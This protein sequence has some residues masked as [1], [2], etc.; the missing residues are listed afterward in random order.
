MAT[1]AAAASSSSSSYASIASCVALNRQQGRPHA[2]VTITGGAN[3]T[4]ANA[5]AAAAAAAVPLLSAHSMQTI[6]FLPFA[7]EPKLDGCVCMY[8]VD[9]EGKKIA[10][11][12]IDFCVFLTDAP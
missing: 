3:K 12:A 4:A 8:D 9:K 11:H 7:F 10:Y 2:G 6:D 1:Q 5:N